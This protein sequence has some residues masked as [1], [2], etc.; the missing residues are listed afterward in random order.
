LSKDSLLEIELIENS[1]TLGGFHR[2]IEINGLNYDIGAFTFDRNHNLFKSFPSIVKLYRSIDNNFGSITAKKSL[3]AYPCTLKGYIRDNGLLSLLSTCI[4]IPFS[5]LYYWRRNTVPAFVKYYIGKSAYQKTG[6]KNYIER[7]YQV[8][9]QDI[10]IQFAHKRLDCIQNTGSLRKITSKKFQGKADVL[11]PPVSTSVLVRPQEGFAKIYSELHKLLLV[12]GVTISLDCEVKSIK[13]LIKDQQQKFEVEFANQTTEIYDSVVSTI[14]IP[15][16]SRL[17]GEPLQKELKSISLLT[18]FYRFQ[19]NLNYDYNVLHNFTAEGAWKKITTFSHY[20][21][22]HE[23]DDYFSVEIT[24]DQDTFPDIAQQQ[25]Q[26]EQHVKSLGL[27]AGQLKLQ[28]SKLTPNAYPVYLNDNVD[29]I[30]TAKN[31]LKDWGLYLAGRQGEFD[32]LNSSDAAGNAVKIA[33]QIKLDYQQ[34]SA[35]TLK[36]LD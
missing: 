32:Y 14:P 1:A 21:G 31:Q 7:L 16:I 24:L 22:K 9:D 6:L 34:D 36:L 26:F 33:N 13:K 20:Y 27:F 8:S 10:D 17:I 12:D 11:T 19:G 29:E 15:V 3:D 30:I 2:N 25:Q 23:G 18:L 5:K 28:G 4:E 35:Q